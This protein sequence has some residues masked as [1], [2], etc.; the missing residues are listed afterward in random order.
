MVLPLLAMF[1]LSV[2]RP[3][4]IVLS[5]LV[6]TGPKRLGEPLAESAY[7]RIVWTNRPP[8]ACVTPCR[9]A[10]LAGPGA[11]AWMLASESRVVGNPIT[12]DCAYADSSRGGSACRLAEQ[13]G[14]DRPR[15][16]ARAS[17]CLSDK[18]VERARHVYDRARRRHQR[19]GTAS[20]PS[21]QAA[22]LLKQRVF[23]GAGHRVLP[24]R[25]PGAPMQRSTALNAGHLFANSR[26][27]GGDSS[28]IAGALL[29]STNLRW[30]GLESRLKHALRRG[31]TN[32]PPSHS[33]SPRLPLPH[34]ALRL[35]ERAGAGGM[36]TV[37]RRRHPTRTQTV[38]VQV[39][40]AGRNHPQA[41][42][43]FASVGPSGLRAPPSG[44]VE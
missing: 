5:F 33:L 2:T 11:R 38:A 15:G 40:Q 1:W 19:G 25:S 3:L 29:W 34:R 44:I 36:G 41:A 22:R 9:C 35:Q 23:P 24:R 39:L 6:A 37:Y 18:C 10:Q 13:I 26:R 16:S 8:C 4:A 20:K 27:K 21:E 17:A 43:R 7:P 28:A 14:G 32:L 31:S 30:P 12:D 42:E